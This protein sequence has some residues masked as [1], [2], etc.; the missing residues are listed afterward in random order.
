MGAYIVRRLISVIP[1]LI[2]VTIVVFLVMR[3]LPGDVAGMILA[4]D[5]ESGSSG[6]MEAR[7]TLREQ[8]GLNLPLHEQYFTWI[9]G[10]LQGDAG[11]SLWS[12]RPVLDEIGRRIPLTIELALLSIAIAMGIGLPAGMIAA[13]KQDSWV[14]YALRGLSI[15]GLAMPP[16]WLGTLLM[17][18]MVVWFNW[19]P[20]LGFVPFFTN[21]WM[22]LQQ[23][24]WPALV[25]GYAT[26]AVIAR[27]TRST[28]LE[29]LREDYVRTARAKGLPT[30]TLVITHTLR[31]AMLPILT[32]AA[33]EF[34]FMLNGTVIMET[35]FTLPGI[36]R[37]LIDAILHRDYPV[38]Q[39]I[40]LMM[41]VSFVLVNLLVDLLYGV[42]DPRIRY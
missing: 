16:F 4:G 1:T 24:I 8:L 10:L 21:P 19:T 31:N 26:A 42:L 9:G 27:M 23:V 33:I 38:V 2:G 11:L 22:N 41:A 37:Y 17:L 32:L 28:M 5:G 20:P 36:G 6:N 25:L 39:A 34:G 29:V 40:I 30:T 35:I 12:G 13:L 7:E 14:D 18:F 3:L 15:G